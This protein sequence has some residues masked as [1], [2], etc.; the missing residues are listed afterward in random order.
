[1]TPVGE[2][3]VVASLSHVCVIGESAMF[4][5]A[6]YYTVGC[7]PRKDNID[8]KKGKLSPFHGPWPSIYG[9]QDSPGL[10][11]HYWEGF[12]CMA[13]PHLWCFSSCITLD[14]LRIEFT[15]V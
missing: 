14:G 7:H 4:G 15:R 11:Q 3:G 10:W 2:T 9:Y 1:M 12:A 6:D 5:G 13:L 8:N